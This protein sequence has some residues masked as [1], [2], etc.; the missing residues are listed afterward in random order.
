LAAC[1]S[2]CPESSGVTHLPAIS[3]CVLGRYVLTEEQ[4]QGASFEILSTLGVCDG[5]YSCVA[6]G[7]WTSHCGP[8][9]V[10][11]LEIVCFQHRCW[12]GLK[13]QQPSFWDLLAWQYP[14]RVMVHTC[15]ICRVG[16]LLVHHSGAPGGGLGT[17]KS[18]YCSHQQFSLFCTDFLVSVFFVFFFNPWY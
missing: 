14:S 5:R 13:S 17:L 6:G 8:D 1:I 16:C 4:H 15:P 18:S 9:W 7:V 2:G 11:P 12:W 10:R 3:H